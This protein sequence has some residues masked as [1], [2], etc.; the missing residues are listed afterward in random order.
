MQ[1]KSY[2]FWTH[3]S[4]FES[5]DLIK[6]LYHKKHKAKL[7]NKNAREIISSF[8]QG[9]EYFRNAA[10][11]SEIVKPLL[12][13]YGILS[14]SRG[15]IYFL[16]DYKIQNNININSHGL[17]PIKW[18]DE[19]N[20][21]IANLPTLKIQ[22]TNGGTFIELCKLTNRNTNYIVHT[23]P[24]PSKTMITKN[25]SAIAKIQNCFEISL[26]ELISRIP[27]LITLYQ[28]TF[29]EL[30]NCFP[31]V[32]FFFS[33]TSQT[34]F[35]ILESNIKLD[36]NE[37]RKKLQIPSDSEMRYETKHHFFGHINHFDCLI[38]HSNL[39]ELIQK[40]PMILNDT[41]ENTY[42]ISRFN[43]IEFSQLDIMYMVSYAMGMLVRYYPAHWA[44][45]I[46][47]QNGDK[48]YPILK[49]TIEYI[50]TF[51]PKLILDELLK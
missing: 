40:A 20:N 33:E 27:A 43:N 1:N 45:I 38:K 2:D 35:F 37:I 14:L 22:S 19:L 41:P 18:V 49:A 13:Y 50:E 29:G 34:S 16:H 24:F 30:S 4:L 31:S 9:R 36:E 28:T 7:S 17:K 5:S 46:G 47:H 42:L 48:A 11:A 26:K 51:F 39:N 6:E 15:L 23:G 25:N 32:V 8:A 10:N 44:S 21:S 12:L 3:I